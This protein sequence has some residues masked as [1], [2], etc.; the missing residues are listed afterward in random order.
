MTFIGCLW[1][2]LKNS[3]GLE[4]MIYRLSLLRCRFILLQMEIP[5]IP[6]IRIL[7]W[8]KM[9]KVLL[10]MEADW[11]MTHYIFTCIMC[12]SVL[13]MI[14]N[15]Y[16]LY[17]WVVLPHPSLS[18]CVCVCVYSTGSIRRPPLVHLPI[19]K[20]LLFKPIKIMLRMG[21]V[22]WVWRHTFLRKKWKILILSRVVSH[23]VKQNNIEILFN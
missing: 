16:M 9:R 14:N 6:C 18:L 19:L 21:P 13:F 11:R 5:L 2:I 3:I 10:I 1:S 8:Q 4:Q 15:A 22:P 12:S 23:T 7:Q 20:H 17:F